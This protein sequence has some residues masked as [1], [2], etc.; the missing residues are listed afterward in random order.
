MH[1][2]RLLIISLTTILVILVVALLLL[3]G[4]EKKI[5]PTPNSIIPTLFQSSSSKSSTVTE[6]LVPAQSTNY[7]TERQEIATEEK[8]TLT[9]ESAIGMLL[10]KLPYSGTNFKME[11]DYG[12]VQ[13]VV[14]I[15]QAREK[16]GNEELDAFLK[17]NNVADKS[18]FH[19]GLLVIQYE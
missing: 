7:Q 18:W 3:Q 13:Y 16:E 8:E 17:E 1:T 15:P 9:R 6:D 2:K 10:K 5:I 11:H 12:K 19:P 4:T 14:T